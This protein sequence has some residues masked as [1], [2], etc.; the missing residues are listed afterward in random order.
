MTMAATFAVERIGSIATM[1]LRIDAVTRSP[2]DR[3]SQIRAERRVLRPTRAA[4]DRSPVFRDRSARA[5]SCQPCEQP[6]EQRA[7]PVCRRRP[8][9]QPRRRNLR[10]SRGVAGGG[11]ASPEVS[12]MAE[13]IASRAGLPAQT[14]N[15][16]A[17]K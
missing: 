8:M 13:S 17:G 11:H 3:R 5:S 14:T 7:M 15:W 16:N 12:N 2:A 10:R 9:T 1:R 6:G 4:G